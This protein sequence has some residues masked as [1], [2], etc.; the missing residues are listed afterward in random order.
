MRSLAKR[1]IRVFRSVLVDVRKL[2]CGAKDQEDR[3]KRYE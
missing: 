2:D 3:K 1:A